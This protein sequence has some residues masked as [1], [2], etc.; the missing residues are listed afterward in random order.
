[1]TCLSP[2]HLGM[3][4]CLAQSVCSV[5]VFLGRQ[6]QVIAGCCATFPWPRH[7]LLLLG[8]LISFITFSFL[9][10]KEFPFLSCF[11]FNILLIK[12]SALIALAEVQSGP[13]CFLFLFFNCFN[14]GNSRKLSLW[15][16]DL[17][18]RATRAFLEVPV[19]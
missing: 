6:E 19:C 9:M 11:A 15:L 10:S 8:L 14:W 18:A 3:R 17:T 5:P 13:T 1:M 2:V 12:A 4:R 7:P 16:P